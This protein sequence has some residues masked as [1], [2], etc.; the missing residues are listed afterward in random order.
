MTNFETITFTYFLGNNP[1]TRTLKIT[2]ED[3]DQDWTDLA[4][5]AYEKA[6]AFITKKYG[7]DDFEC[8]AD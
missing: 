1:T 5:E 3:R 2:V 8:W 7:T 6:C 4:D